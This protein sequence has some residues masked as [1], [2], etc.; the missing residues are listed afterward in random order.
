MAGRAWGPCRLPGT[1]LTDSAPQRSSPTSVLLRFGERCLGGNH[2]K[3]LKHL[4][5]VY[6]LLPSSGLVLKIN[7]A[8]SFQAPKIPERVSVP[9]A[10]DR[11]NDWLEVSETCF[12]QVSCLRGLVFLVSFVFPFL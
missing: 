11:V 2:F 3:S 1:E 5:S 6:P 8:L 12:P 9:M 10:L 4:V 7:F